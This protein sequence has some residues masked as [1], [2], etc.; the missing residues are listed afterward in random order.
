M[1]VEAEI[2][3]NRSLALN[4]KNMKAKYRRAMASFELGKFTTALQDIDDVIK[5]LPDPN[6]NKEAVELKQKIQDK[7][8]TGTKPASPQASEPPPGFKRMQ[9]VEEDESDEEQEKEPLPD[10][11]VEHSSAGVEEAKNA[12]NKAFAAGDVA[13]SIDCFTKALWLLECK[14]V[15]GV[16]SEMHSILHSNRAF[17]YLKKEKWPEAEQDCST[18][19]SLNAKNTKARY[20]RAMASFELGKLQA[21]LE[22]TEQVIKDLPDPNSH[23]DAA[24]LKARILKDERMT[25]KTSPSSG[26][27][28]PPPGFKRMQIVEED[29]SEPEQVLSP[30]SPS[31]PSR[32]KELYPDI[33]VAHTKEAIDAAKTEANRLFS[34]G[35]LAESI[36][37]FSKALWVA[38]TKHVDGLATETQ[39]ILHAN[40]AF[41]YVKSEQWADAEDDCSRALALNAKHVK[42]KYRR[43]LAR[44]E[45]GKFE[46]ALQDVEEVSGAMPDSSE[47]SE[48]KK[49]IMGSLKKDSPKAV[50]SSSDQW[51]DIAIE[52]SKAGIEK[53]KNEANSLFSRGAI[54]EAVRW[55]SKCL[56]LVNSKKVADISTEM[57]SILH[58]NRSFAYIKLQRWAE[59]EDDCMKALFLNE[60]NVKALYRRGWARFELGQ[61]KAALQDVESVLSDFPD[62]SSNNKEAIEL[63]Q[64][65]LGR[66]E[67]EQPKQAAKADVWKTVEIIDGDAADRAKAS[68]PAPSVETEAPKKKP[69][70]LVTEV[71]SPTGSSPPATPSTNVAA[72]ARRGQT[73]AA[74][75]SLGVPTVPASTPKSA[76][77]LLRNFNSL[78]RHPSVL[79][80]YVRDRVPPQTAYGLFSK[81]PIEADDLAVLL[82][83]I[84]T[85]VDEGMPPDTGVEYLRQLLR[86]KN[87][88]T[89]FSMLTSGEKQVARSL[90]AGGATS[91][92]ATFVRTKF[93]AILD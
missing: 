69:V 12:G 73:G 79:A 37:W 67:K 18:A 68:R 87:A 40:R 13:K 39:A 86:T 24:E 30:A 35:Q 85:A 81:N 23:K 48:L 80:R 55:F 66:L 76:L 50:A 59:A 11:K 60:K 83:A 54:E 20:R 4:A 61:T 78:K 44:T 63:K 56:W 34:N 62:A 6:N 36:R 46:A 89:Q 2:D 15:A 16:S 29:D 22:D 74:A 88:E 90:V 64:R 47:V 17:A 53:G 14:K 51:P 21:A 92:A 72:G 75:R 27:S 25:K 28:A 5:D 82:S 3:C 10:I 57:H 84:R 9:I 70:E 33:K 7:L 45:L 91:E 19:L 58:S 8:R 32:E 41:A 31:S 42:A 43:A 52:H 77:E 49:R 26:S 65:I 38:E 93:S 1:G 71:K